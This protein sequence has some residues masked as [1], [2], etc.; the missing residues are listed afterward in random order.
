MQTPSPEAL[1]AILQ[2]YPTGVS[3]PKLSKRLGERA[4]V[5][6]RALAL[7]G[8]GFGNRRGPGWVRVEQTD[9]V[10]NITI[11]PAGRQALQQ[12]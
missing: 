6:L 12:P 11:T 5:V 10:W 8:D 2:E 3:L 7:M 4:S 1:L 9:G